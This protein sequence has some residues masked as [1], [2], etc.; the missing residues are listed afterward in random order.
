MR[1]E[2]VRALVN[3]QLQERFGLAVLPAGVIG[4]LYQPETFSIRLLKKEI[5]GRRV[6]LECSLWPFTSVRGSA[7]V[8]TQ[9]G[10]NGSI[11]LG[12]F[13]RRLEE[14]GRAVDAH[15]LLQLG[16]EN[17]SFHGK[18]AVDSVLRNRLADFLE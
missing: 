11:L 13:T 6:V 4:V 17:G 9:E 1:Q 7:N 15:I 14:G 8:G 12:F 3:G 2:I 16:G 10:G 18:P 5:H